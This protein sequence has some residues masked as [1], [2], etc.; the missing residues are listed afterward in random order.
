MEDNYFK[1]L[2]IDLTFIFG[3]FKKVVTTKL[4]PKYNRHRRFK[5]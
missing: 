3:I 5:G 1:I 4:K 2:L